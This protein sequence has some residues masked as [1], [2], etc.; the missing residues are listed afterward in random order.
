LLAMHVSLLW[1]AGRF[2]SRQPAPGLGL[3]STLSHLTP[4]PVFKL[5]FVKAGCLSLFGKDWPFIGCS[6]GG[7]ASVLTIQ[8]PVISEDWRRL[9][10]R[11][12][13]GTVMPKKGGSLAN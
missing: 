10:V 3:F 8:F 2:I 11:P 9:A 1:D 5:A 6:S 7:A 4:R 12:F 13:T